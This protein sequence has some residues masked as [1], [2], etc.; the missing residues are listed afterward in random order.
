MGTKVVVMPHLRGRKSLSRAKEPPGGSG[1]R[2]ASAEGSP[3]AAVCV[4]VFCFGG[5]KASKLGNALKAGLPM[6]QARLH[7]AAL[8]CA[9][10]PGYTALAA[11]C[12]STLPGAPRAP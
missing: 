3:W 1:E 8:R 10:L 4:Q 9:I 12:L 2:R 11:I 7:C 6:G 5:G